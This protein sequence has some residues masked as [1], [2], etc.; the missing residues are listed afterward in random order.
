M[1]W[2]TLGRTAG[3]ADHSALWEVIGDMVPDKSP[4][5]PLR[6]V[7]NASE[8]D[9]HRA[10]RLLSMLPPEDAHAVLTEDGNMSSEDAFLAI[11]AAQVY[12]QDQEDRA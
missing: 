5:Q 3:T 11:Q 8:Q 2:E 6:L 12:L 10:A 1:L 9:I 7:K 4:Q